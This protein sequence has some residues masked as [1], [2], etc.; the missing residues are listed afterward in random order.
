MALVDGV[1]LRHRIPWLTAVGLVLA[2][3]ALLVGG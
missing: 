3:A 2:S 1:V